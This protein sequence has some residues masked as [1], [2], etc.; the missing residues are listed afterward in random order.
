M[1]INIKYAE[2]LEKI[3]QLISNSDSLENLVA[4]SQT[5]IEKII[6]VELSGI[7]LY[8]K[9][10]NKLKLMSY[11]GFTKAE[12]ILAEKSALERHPGWVCKNKKPILIKDTLI[13]KNIITTDS[14]RRW[15]TRSRVCIPILTKHQISLTIT[16]YLF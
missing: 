1:S 9:K 16:M 13:E 15:K 5:I 7:F 2:K 8:D 14:K 4:N 12:S 3:T 10:S 11:R 6:L